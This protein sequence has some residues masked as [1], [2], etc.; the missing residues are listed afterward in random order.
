MAHF[1]VL[2]DKPDVHSLGH[3][4]RPRGNFVK[5]IPPKGRIGGRKARQTVERRN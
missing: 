5:H 2:R 1:S 3:K 4:R